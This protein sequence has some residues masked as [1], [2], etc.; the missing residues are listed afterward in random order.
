MAGCAWDGEAS[1]TGDIGNVNIKLA[2]TTNEAEEEEEAAT[3]NTQEP[4]TLTFKWGYLNLFA[5]ACPGPR[6]DALYERR[7]AARL[8]VQDRRHWAHLLRPWPEDLE[9]FFLSQ[10][11]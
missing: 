1:A 4:V 2:Q 10:I 11:L 9:P 8:G 3:I 5:K 7:G 6:G